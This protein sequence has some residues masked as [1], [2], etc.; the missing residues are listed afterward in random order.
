MPLL[1]IYCPAEDEVNQLGEL[2]DDERQ[3]VQRARG[4]DAAVFGELVTRHSNSA[5][6]VAAVV[7]GTAEGAGDAVQN[8]S[9]KAWQAIETV[10]PERGFRSWFLRIVAN[11]ARNDRRS[12]NRRAALAV[13]AA[14]VR[15][16]DAATPEVASVTAAER[17]MVVGALNRLNEADRLVVAL[18]FFEDLT[19]AE[20]ALVLDC[21]A[22]TVKSRLSRAMG[23]LRR[24][25]DDGS[26]GIDG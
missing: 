10:D 6:R 15:P 7:L 13:R 17:E 1:T 12:R 21:P 3:L 25:L 20:M 24:E 8:A 14:A 16:I 19:Q 11:T 5:R 26:G 18:R 23:R 2:I 4:G 9:L 22:G